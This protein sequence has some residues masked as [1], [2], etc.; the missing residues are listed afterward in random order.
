MIPNAGG[1][2]LVVGIEPRVPI[3]LGMPIA[4]D[5]GDVRMPGVRA[6]DRTCAELTLQA[7]NKMV[8]V[9]KSR[10]CI[11]ASYVN[12][13]KLLSPAPQPRRRALISR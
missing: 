13:P 7:S 12:I 3:E 11:E 9:V 4:P 1:D 2:A 5:I 6:V 8:A 10:R